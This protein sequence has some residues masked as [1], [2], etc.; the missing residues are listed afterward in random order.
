MSERR[1]ETIVQK[2]ETEANRFAAGILM[3][4][5]WFISDMRKLGDADVEHVKRLRDNTAQASKQLLPATSS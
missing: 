1:I 2:Q 5:P 4:K 3:P